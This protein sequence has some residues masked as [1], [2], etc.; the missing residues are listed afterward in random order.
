MSRSKFNID[1]PRKNFS[2]ILYKK[3]GGN[4]GREQKYRSLP[5]RINSFN[6]REKWVPTIIFTLKDSELRIG[7]LQRLLRCSKKIL[8]E[9]LNILILHKIVE[10]RKV[11]KGNTIESYYKLTDCGSELLPILVNMKSF[12]CK[13][14]ENIKK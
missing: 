11:Y 13:F 1:L 9:Q 12:G 10:N 8:I 3:C 6:F 5:S 2:D 14:E 7:E 4:Y